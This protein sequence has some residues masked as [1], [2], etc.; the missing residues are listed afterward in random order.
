MSQSFE[1]GKVL[2]VADDLTGANDAAVQF[3]KTGLKTVTLRQGIGGFNRI[4]EHRSSS[5]ARSGKER[6]F[7][8]LSSISRKDGFQEDRL[9][10]PGKHRGRTNGPE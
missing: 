7:T 9:H 2:V 10:P 6:F 4:A 1:N 5:S 3:A 8:G